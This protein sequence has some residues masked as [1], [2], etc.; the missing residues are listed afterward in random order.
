MSDRPVVYDTNRDGKPLFFR[1]NGVSGFSYCALCATFR[2][3]DG[4]V[5]EEHVLDEG[6]Y[7][8]CSDC[9]MSCDM[10]T[11][12]NV[13]TSS[14]SSTRK[15]L[16]ENLVSGDRLVDDAGRII[17]IKGDAMGRSDLMN[18]DF[19]PPLWWCTNGQTM[20]KRYLQTLPRSCV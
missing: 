16:H 19:D 17:V 18:V 3:Y 14:D 12:E 10:Y 5:I 7:E 13:T 20:F 6:Q 4:A 15:I 9:D 11:K 1:A 8:V 2:A